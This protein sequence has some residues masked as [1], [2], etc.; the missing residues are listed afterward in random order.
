[1]WVG[2]SDVFPQPR[3]LRILLRLRQMREAGLRLARDF[4]EL[5]IHVVRSS[6]ATSEGL[7]LQNS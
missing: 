1:M 3:T 7:L 4:R 2:G 6:N 5:D